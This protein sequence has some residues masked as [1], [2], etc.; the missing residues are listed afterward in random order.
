MYGYTVFLFADNTIAVS[1]CVTR[2]QLYTSGAGWGFGVRLIRHKLH[3]VRIVTF[4][5]GS[6]LIL[7]PP[8]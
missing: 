4:V 1:L 5:C 6:V 2:V 3:H 7:F 8:N